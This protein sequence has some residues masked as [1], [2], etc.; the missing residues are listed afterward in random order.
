M[1][2]IAGAVMGMVLSF[3]GVL[4]LK[5]LYQWLG[6]FE[7]ESFGKYFDLLL[8]GL[9]MSFLGSAL[10]NACSDAGELALARSMQLICSC[11][12]IALCMPLMKELLEKALMML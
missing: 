6:S 12:V 8:K 11:A 5:E 1:A 7:N 9:G 10:S 3:A 4:L 2:P